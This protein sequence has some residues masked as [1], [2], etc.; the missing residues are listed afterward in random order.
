MLTT[1]S[2]DKILNYDDIVQ[3]F[4]GR[5]KRK[6]FPAASYLAYLQFG[7]QIGDLEITADLVNYAFQTLYN[8]LPWIDRIYALDIA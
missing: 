7:L 2:D 8:K 3:T 4:Y 6:E 1:T 5:A